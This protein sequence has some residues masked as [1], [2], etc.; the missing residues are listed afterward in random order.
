VIFVSEILT[1]ATKTLKE[2]VRQPRNLILTL[3]L[4]IAFMVIFGL[5]FGGATTS[6][7]KVGIVNDDAG[8][9]AKQYVTHL[10]DL[11]YA[12]GKAVVAP[13]TFTSLAAA[14]EALKSRDID[15]VVHIPAGFTQDIQP[16]TTPGTTSPVPGA[17]QPAQTAPPKGTSVTLL[18]D[19]GNANSNVARQVL[20]AY[21]QQFAATASGRAPIVAT[22]NQQVTDKELTAFDFIAPGLMVYA[23]LS[24]APQAAAAL[25]RETELKTI[26]R[27][28]LSPLTSVSLLGGVAL[29]QLAI[30]SRSCS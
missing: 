1:V 5:A 28:R 7:Y 19:P 2:S 26:D 13:Q 16:T 23:V 9:A 15:L 14:Q 20:E 25:A 11:K 27:I 17:S 3:G 30:A 8:D 29:A 10:A 4:P 21:T 24:I 12:S 6:T 18:G 22:V